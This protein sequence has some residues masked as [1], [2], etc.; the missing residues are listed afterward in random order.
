MVDTQEKNK[1]DNK[2]TGFLKWL[3]EDDSPEIGIATKEPISEYF[4]G[5]KTEF[6]KINW[7]EKE[8]IGNELL[9]VIVIVAIISGL[10]YFI[11]LG[12]D[13]FVKIFN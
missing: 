6:Q 3:T 7:P 8:Q 11:D 1:S 10:V 4:Q 5:V 9:T 13:R 12:L 2:P